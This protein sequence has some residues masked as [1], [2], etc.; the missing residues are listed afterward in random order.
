MKLLIDTGSDIQ[1]LESNILPPELNLEIFYQTSLTLEL[2][3]NDFYNENFILDVY[4]LIVKN[5]NPFSLSRKVKDK[6]KHDM[7]YMLWRECIPSDFY[8]YI[9][10]EKNF[11]YLNHRDVGQ[12]G[13]LE[14]VGGFIDQ[15][16]QNLRMLQGY[17][18][19]FKDI[20]QYV[21]SHVF[22]EVYTT[23]KKRGFDLKSN[24][25]ILFKAYRNK[26]LMREQSTA[27]NAATYQVQNQKETCEFDQKPIKN[28]DQFSDSEERDVKERAEKRL[29]ER[30]E[31]VEDLKVKKHKLKSEEN[32]V[33]EGEMWNRLNELNGEL[34]KIRQSKKEEKKVSATINKM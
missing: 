11:I 29:A 4:V 23:S 34:K 20:Y 24:L 7:V 1:L 17:L 13:V 9:C 15:G 26:M 30:P 2:A 27:K 10:D 5:L 14:I 16:K 3:K 18:A 32:K 25:H 6:T 22:P 12:P 19:R 28:F 33:K 31:K 21:Y 8:G